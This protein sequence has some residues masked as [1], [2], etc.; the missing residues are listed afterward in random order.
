MVVL[1]LL[2][3]GL[4][5]A[6]PYEAY[7]ANRGRNIQRAIEFP[8]EYE[9]IKR[10]YDAATGAFNL[11]ESVSGNQGYTRSAWIFENTMALLGY[12]HKAWTTEY[13]FGSYVREVE[14]IKNMASQGRVR[15]DDGGENGVS[16]ARMQE[17]YRAIYLGVLAG[18]S[19]GM[20]PY[21]SKEQAG[22]YGK[23]LSPVY[24]FRVGQQAMRVA[25]LTEM[26][27]RL[28][29]HRAELATLY[30]FSRRYCSDTGE[31]T[32]IFRQRINVPGGGFGGGDCCA[33]IVSA[34]MDAK[35]A[36]VAALSVVDEKIGTMGEL[37]CLS[38]LT[39]LH[40]TKV[41]LEVAE[42]EL[43]KLSV[44]HSLLSI[45]EKNGGGTK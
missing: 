33:A 25:V 28:A 37:E 44:N 45:M 7:E 19:Y 14:G 24:A 32:R 40:N 23:V 36:I 12:F 4:V 17:Y 38:L 35:A 1:L 31:F 22:K 29:Y 18:F 21:P 39:A 30:Y 13:S 10:L 27:E 5:F 42:L 15:E 8:R 3:F 43:Y 20:V 16:E 2:I 9:F 26:A 6:G 34:I 41:G 11:S